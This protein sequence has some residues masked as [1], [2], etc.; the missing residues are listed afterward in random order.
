MAFQVLAA[1]KD[2][3]TGKSIDEIKDHLK[4]IYHRTI[5]IDVLIDNLDCLV[6]GGRVSRLAGALTKLINLKLIIRLN[7][8]SLDALLSRVVARKTLSS[9]A[10][11]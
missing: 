11:L 7:E 9:I 8:E 2:L 1:A 4:D 5:T 3:E 10:R 6:A